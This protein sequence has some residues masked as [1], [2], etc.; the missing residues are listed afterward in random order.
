MWV[1]HYA[2]CYC[3]HGRQGYAERTWAATNSLST[4]MAIKH[5]H[6]TFMHTIQWIL[7]YKCIWFTQFTRS[8]KCNNLI[9]FCINL[10]INNTKYTN[11]NVKFA[12][13]CLIC[14]DSAHLASD[15][16]HLF[17]SLFKCIL[18]LHSICLFFLPPIQTDEGGAPS[19]EIYIV[20][21]ISLSGS[22]ELSVT[23]KLI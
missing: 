13:V 22:E 3:F 11:S 15:F 2:W 16:L 7:L 23:V 10:S 18:T 1:Q 6:K 19:H 5:V 17:M 12:F 21:H 4:M 8:H 14:Q 9:Y 20:N